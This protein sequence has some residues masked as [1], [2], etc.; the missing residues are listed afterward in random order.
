MS[1]Y[2]SNKK[3]RAESDTASSNILPLNK[4]ILV[5]IME[6]YC[7][8]YKIRRF[9]YR[10]VLRIYYIILTMNIIK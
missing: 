6:S 4:S 10:L 9:K 2:C 5:L 7:E 1:R 3:V 8:M